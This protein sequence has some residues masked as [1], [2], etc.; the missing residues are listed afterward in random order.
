MSDVREGL[1]E[2]ANL[3]TLVTREPRHHQLAAQRP[4]QVAASKAP[5]PNQPC[6]MSPGWIVTTWDRP[7]SSLAFAL[8]MPTTATGMCDTSNP[9]GCDKH[10]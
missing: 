7:V 2:A 1:S 10:V 8:A 3:S 9:P 6:V 5:R 4:P